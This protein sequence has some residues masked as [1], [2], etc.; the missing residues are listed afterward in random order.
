MRIVKRLQNLME[1]NN[2]S[3]AD[4]VKLTGMKK[5]TLYRLFDED[6]NESKILIE[7]LK[8]L[9]RALNSTLDDLV[10]GTEEELEYL[11]SYNYLKA[12]NINNISIYEREIII[13]I[14]DKFPFSGYGSILLSPQEILQKFIEAYGA[15]NSIISSWGLRILNENEIQFVN[16]SLNKQLDYLLSKEEKTIQKA[17]YLF[18]DNKKFLNLI[19][20]LIKKIGTFSNRD[21][22]RLD[23]ADSIYETFQLYHE[24]FL[25]GLERI[26]N[27][28]DVMEQQKYAKEFNNIV[29]NVKLIRQVINSFAN[30]NE[31]FMLLMD[32][33]KKK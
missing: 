23:K 24:Y 5:S 28:K 8:P 2:V 1:K 4:L 32:K 19:K 17:D 30:E 10:Y 14:L 26:N 18:G 12:D 20:P 31:E 33:L 22:T 3:R 29:E 27:T 11:F 25:Y 13:D 15:G 7:T 16:E 21:I 6:I 9:A